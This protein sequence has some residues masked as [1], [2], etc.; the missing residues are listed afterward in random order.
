MTAT[1]AAA[2]ATAGAAPGR[3]VAAALAPAAAVLDALGVRQLVAQA[4]LQPS[5][6]PGQL[7]W[8][9]AQVLLLGHL[10]R[11]RLEGLQERRAAE[12]PAARAVAAVHLRFVAHADLPHLDPRAELRCQL[13]DQFAEIDAPVGGE[14]E[15][16]LRAVERLFDAGELHA[17]AALA[18]L[19][20]RDPVRLLLAMLVLHPRD[21]VVAGGDADDP[22]RLI[23]ARRPLRFELRNR[24][25]HRAKRR[26]AV[27][28]DDDGV[29]E[30]RRRLRVPDHIR[31]RAADRR[32][33]DGD[34]PTA[35]RRCHNCNTTQSAT[36]FTPA[37]RGGAS[38]TSAWSTAANA[39]TPRSRW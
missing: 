24:P 7:R 11:D 17:E 23:A 2:A 14:I 19:E 30:A 5:A 18:N 1:G 34:E 37:L 9:E 16:Q 8:V 15:D 31:A 39:R 22:R 35:R 26:R 21:D 38:A 33:L 10:D 20:Q 29:A 32:Q 4:A 25:D 13:A 27:A 36:I 3:I 28:L 12:R 6:Q